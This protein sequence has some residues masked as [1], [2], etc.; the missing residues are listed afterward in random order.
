MHTDSG[1]EF[2]WED[3]GRTDSPIQ[4]IWGHGWGQSGAALLPLAESL[5]GF[6]S[7]TVIDLP[8]FGASPV[9]P[10]SWGSAEYADCVAAW[11]QKMPPRCR[12]WIGH[13]FGCKVGLHIA[14]RYPGLLSGLVLMA[15]PGLPRKR[16]W[17][18]RLR[19]I[20]R[21]Y[22]FKLGKVIFNEGT[23]LN[24][25]R[26]RLGSADYRNA[27]VMRPILSRVVAEN[28]SEVA[29]RVACPTLLIYGDKDAD[30]PP[31]IGERLQQLIPNATLVVLEGFDHHTLLGAG[32]HQVTSRIKSFAEKTVQCL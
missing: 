1:N 3:V 30:T 26:S 5:G 20:T 27:G 18:D 7:S 11:L 9:P 21:K 2:F 4:L 10:L 6:A 28:L 29:S 15:A 8:G 19:F 17:P 12:V 13:S 25:Q 16:S 24:K 31:E 14:A 32:R 22:L 23:M